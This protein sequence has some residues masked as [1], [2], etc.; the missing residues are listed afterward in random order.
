MSTRHRSLSASPQNVNW[1]L[2]P[3]TL[4]AIAFGCLNSSDAASS[5]TSTGASAGC[6]LKPVDSHQLT[7]LWVSKVTIHM[8]A[9]CG[10]AGGQATQ[11]APDPR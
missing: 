3:I 7:D 6:E 8:L 10:T 2:T 5:S 11:S 9:V 1:N 4:A